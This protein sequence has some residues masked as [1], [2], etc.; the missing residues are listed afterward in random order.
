MA[1]S[2]RAFATLDAHPVADGH[3]LIIP[4]R[5]VVS[6]F[7]LTA[8]EFADIWPLLVRV[9]AVIEETRRPDGY[10]VGWNNGVAAGQS[11]PHVHCHVIPR[12]EGDVPVPRG[13]IR[14]LLLIAGPPEHGPAEAAQQ[15]SPNALA[16][17]KHSVDA[18]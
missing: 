9:R 12:Y 3:A 8:A 10:N 18:V 14:N 5:H 2:E 15:R 16:P 1:E 17:G 13:G 4:R 7:D 6:L 11:V